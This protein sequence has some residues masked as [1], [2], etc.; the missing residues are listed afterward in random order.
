MAEREETLHA[1]RI[2]VPNYTGYAKPDLIDDNWIVRESDTTPLEYILRVCPI[3]CYPSEESR[4]NEEFYRQKEARRRENELRLPIG[5]PLL[6]HADGA[7]EIPDFQSFLAA[8]ISPGVGPGER[9]FSFTA[10]DNFELI[11]ELQADFHALREYMKDLILTLRSADIGD[12]DT[13]K[14][15]RKILE[16]LEHDR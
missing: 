11:E 13:Q 1:P 3:G 8:G 14:S 6:D 2:H 12:P 4:L 5:A 15:L 10:Q 16:G 9:P 7:P